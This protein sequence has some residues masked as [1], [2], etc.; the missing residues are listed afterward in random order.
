MEKCD[1]MVCGSSKFTIQPPLAGNFGTFGITV[2]KIILSFNA[3]ASVKH[4]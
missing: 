1:A 2:Y 3:I 4:F